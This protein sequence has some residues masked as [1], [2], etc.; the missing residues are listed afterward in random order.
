MNPTNMTA[1]PRQNANIQQQSS[2]YP[3]HLN[4]IS[5][6]LSTLPPPPILQ[7]G[8]TEPTIRCRPQ[9]PPKPQIDLVRYSMANVNKGKY[10]FNY[11]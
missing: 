9:V 5:D 1:V 10:I 8:A 3:E 11:L 7:G 4:G 2:H 6:D